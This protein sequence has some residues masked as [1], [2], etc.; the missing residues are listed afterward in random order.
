MGTVLGKL[1]KPGNQQEYT[2][3]LKKLTPEERKFLDFRDKVLALIEQE[4]KAGSR[5]GGS[6]TR[7]ITVSG[8]LSQYKGV[9]LINVPGLTQPP[10][11]GKGGKQ[12]PPPGGKQQQPPAK[13]GKQQPPQSGK[14]Q[15]PPAKGGQTAK[16]AAAPQKAQQPKPAP[17]Q[18]PTPPPNAPVPAKPA[19]QQ[20]PTAPPKPAP[21][22]KKPSDVDK[23]LREAAKRAGLL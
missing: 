16:P 10:Q 20:K 5:G 7:R 6:V 13:G 4:T 21:P 23:R 22:Q 17:P 3:A 8:P 2:K 11:G 1:G 9:G 14:Q 18:K 19:P 12:Q 15:P